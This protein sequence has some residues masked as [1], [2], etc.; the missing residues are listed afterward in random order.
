MDLPV[1]TVCSGMDS[2]ALLETNLAIAK[3]FVP[4]TDEQR[5]ALR[6]KVR[7]HAAKG[8]HEVYKTQW[9]RADI[10]IPDG[11]DPNPNLD[12]EAPVF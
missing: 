9:H 10:A 12:T 4:L 6:E 5:N 1:S 3:S 11:E 7:P 8:M 2:M